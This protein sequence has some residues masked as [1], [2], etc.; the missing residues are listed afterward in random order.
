MLIARRLNCYHA[1][2]P[3]VVSTL[4]TGVFISELTGDAPLSSQWLGLEF[5]TL[6]IAQLI[7][8]TA[9]GW[10]AQIQYV[11]IRRR[12]EQAFRSL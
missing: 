10:Y 11:Q 8:M 2:F 1:A 6:S 9:V 4:L 7:A 3:G 12:H 5:S